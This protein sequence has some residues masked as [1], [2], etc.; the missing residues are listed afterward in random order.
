MSKTKMSKTQTRRVSLFDYGIVTSLF[1]ITFKKK[2]EQ[3]TPPPS[4]F[5]YGIADNR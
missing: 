1:L 4:L 3:N 5:Y 2:N